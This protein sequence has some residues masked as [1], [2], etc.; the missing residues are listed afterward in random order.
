[1]TERKKFD[2]DRLD[3]YCKENNVTLL[4]DYSNHFLTKNSIING[5]CTYEN[6]ENNFEKKYSNLLA[7]GGYCVTCIKLIA[8]EKRKH[9]CLKKYGVENVSKSCVYKD[10]VISSKF[11]FNLLQDYC[12][13]NK[14]LL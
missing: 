4:E 10:T 9:F 6:C 14:I 12:S 3:K 11:N 5:N 13:K 1:M 8:N 7:T 2:F